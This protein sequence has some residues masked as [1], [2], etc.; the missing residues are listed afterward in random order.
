MRQAEYPEISGGIIPVFTKLK[1]VLFP[2]NSLFGWFGKYFEN[3]LIDFLK[4]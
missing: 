3:V 2:R 1:W 4:V